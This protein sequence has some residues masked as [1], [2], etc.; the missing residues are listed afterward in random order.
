[1]QHDMMTGSLF[2]CSLCECTH[3]LHGDI[4]LILL[5]A[6]ARSEQAGPFLLEVCK[7]H[8]QRSCSA[9]TEFDTACLC[10]MPRLTRVWQTTISRPQ[11]AC[12]VRLLSTPACI[13][14]S[15]WHLQSLTVCHCATMICKALCFNKVPFQP[16][17]Q[18]Q[19]E[20][21]TAEFA[22]C[23]CMPVAVL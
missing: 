1:M 22:R 10:V 2:A 12:S 19:Q 20:C 4:I 18:Q 3:K 6:T 13:S 15:D 16:A 14:Q 17:R 11:R 5:D 7:T 9:S 8:F 23:M 21:H